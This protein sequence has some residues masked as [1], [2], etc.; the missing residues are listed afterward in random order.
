[1]LAAP[2]KRLRCGGRAAVRVQQAVEQ[3]ALVR[4]NNVRGEQRAWV[5]LDDGARRV[6]QKQ[7]L[8]LEQHALVRPVRGARHCEALAER[9]G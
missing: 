2:R 7:R 5:A 6:R 9:G 4:Q 1:V 8:Q 3:P